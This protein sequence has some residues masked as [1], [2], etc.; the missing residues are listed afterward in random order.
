[1]LNRILAAIVFTT[2]LAISGIGSANADDESS[3][4]HTDRSSHSYQTGHSDDGHGFK[5]HSNRIV[6]SR[7][8]NRRVVNDTLPVRKLLD[9]DRSYRGYRVKTVRVKVKPHRSH[10]RIKLLVNGHM[11]D[12]DHI[13]ENKWITLRTDDD[14]TIGRDLRSLKLHI[15][16]KAFIKNV[17]VTLA[18]PRRPRHH[19]DAGW[20]GGANGAPDTVKYS[21]IDDPVFR[22][23]RV[24][25]HDVRIQSAAL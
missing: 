22:I 18:K 20:S 8:L 9:L 6:V 23:L 4:N 17:E 3:N 16:G 7:K 2:S 14:K 12:R 21:H 13:D 25:L 15:R 11:V 1:M 10:G 5:K 19:A 24:I